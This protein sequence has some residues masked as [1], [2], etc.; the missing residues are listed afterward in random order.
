MSG[1]WKG[2]FELNM[3]V[4]VGM[5]AL[6]VFLW[7]PLCL[8]GYH[9]MLLLTNQTT[10]E[11]MRHDRISYLKDLPPGVLPFDQGL[12]QNLK[13]FFC[14]HPYAKTQT[15]WTVQHRQQEGTLYCGQL[16]ANSYYSCC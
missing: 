8:V 16:F 10:W 7:F 14:L 13:T 2:W 11:L 15:R 5:L 3:L 9:T 12:F 4:V 6:F 1:Y